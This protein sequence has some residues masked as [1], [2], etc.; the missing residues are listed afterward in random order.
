MGPPG[1]RMRVGGL[2]R[3][4]FRLCGWPERYLGGQPGGNN[5]GPNWSREVEEISQILRNL[6]GMS[7]NNGG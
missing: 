3:G 4:Y 5:Y 6:R 7:I 1:D 2:D